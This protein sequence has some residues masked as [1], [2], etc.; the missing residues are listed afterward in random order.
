M[1]EA[2]LANYYDV[3]GVSPQATLAEIRT[4]YHARLKVFA[5]SIHSSSKPEGHDLDLLHEAFSTLGD[6]D[7]RCAYDATLNPDTNP[8][9]VAGGM[10]PPP[11]VGAECR[12]ASAEKPPVDFSKNFRFTGEGG[13]YFRIWI[14]NLCLSILTLGIYSAWAKV[15]REQYFHRNLQL[16]GSGFEYHA[17]PTVILKGRI[18]AFMMLALF[19]GSQHLGGAVHGVVFLCLMLAFPWLVVRTM[20]FRAINTSYRGLRFGF[21][22]TYGQAFKVFLGYGI[23]VPLSLGLAFPLYYRQMRKFVI[24]HA[25]FGTTPFACEVGIGLIY[26][27]FVLPG[28][29]AIAMMIVVFV[30][31]LQLAPG[32]G[33][34]GAL[35]LLPF[36]ML[37][38]MLLPVVAYL[39][40][41]A[42]IVVRTSNAVWNH[43][44]LGAH[45]FSCDLPVGGYLGLVL[46]NWLGIV[47]TLGLFSPW[48]KVRMARFRA[49]H[50]TIHAVGSLDD[51]V[52]GE[53]SKVSALGDEAADMFDMDIAL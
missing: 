47:F 31:G 34:G 7:A 49:E 1:T 11:S 41:H 42:L 44:R 40:I 18:I 14:V 29:A 9:S 28:L 48:A 38:L 24:D 13:E 10:A 33:S 37:F 30:L 16:D 20:R 39:L 43:T 51:F 52:A 8:A 17:K 22:A 25:R 21:D 5:A 50:L 19:S 32:K 15:R 12:D 35:L 3:L 36:L 26:R 6:L 45:R 4:A 46:T 23:L 53:T 2:A 27:I